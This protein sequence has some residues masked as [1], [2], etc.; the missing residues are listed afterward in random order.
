MKTRLFF[1][2][3]FLLLAGIVCSC[4]YGNDADFSGGEGTG[5]SLA[6]F[7]VT[8]NTLYT[9]DPAALKVF[10]LSN[11]EKPQLKRNLPVGFGVETIFPYGENL[12]LGTATGMYIYDIRIPERPEKISFYEHVYSCDPVVTDGNYA[13]VTL[14]TVNQQCW[15][16]INELQIIDIRNRLKPALVKQVPLTQPMGLAVRNDTLWVCDDGLKLF[17]VKDK[18]DIKL[19]RHFTGIQAYDVIWKDNLVLVTGDTGFVQ[20][21]IENNGIRKLSEIYV[22][23]D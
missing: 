3:R 15:H 11:P 19:L 21:K 10:D 4:Q 9:V 6:R 5:G 20:Y 13:Y 12:F 2:A 17:D 8:G 14:T 16:S 7:T 1:A 22:Q 18:S 23:N